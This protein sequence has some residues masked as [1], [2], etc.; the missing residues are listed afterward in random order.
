M[1]KPKSQACSGILQL[2][3][4]NAPPPL[5]MDSWM[6][7]FFPCVIVWWHSEVQKKIFQPMFILDHEVHISC[8]M[9]WH[10]AMFFQSLTET[11]AIVFSWKRGHGSCLAIPWKIQ[12][13]QLYNAHDQHCIHLRPDPL[14]FQCLKACL[15]VALS[16]SIRSILSVAPRMTSTFCLKFLAIHAFDGF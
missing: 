14:N 15:L 3:W 16:H 11:A 2:T 10:T 1:D 9:L 5:P 4:K 12:L 6:F 7:S 13:S 8:I